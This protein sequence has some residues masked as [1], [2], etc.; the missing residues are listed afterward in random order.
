M[1]HSSS[2]PSSDQRLEKIESVVAHLQHDIDSLNRSLLSQLRRLQEFESRFSR[3]EQE[4]QMI[5]AP[6]ESNN[7]DPGDERPP[8]Y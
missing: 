7:S 3:L 6:Q 1:T 8:H 2:W 5:L 4:I